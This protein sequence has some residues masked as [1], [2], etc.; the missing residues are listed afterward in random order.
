MPR[1]RVGLMRQVIFVASLLTLFPVRAEVVPLVE[2]ESGTTFGDGRLSAVFDAVD[3]WPS[4]FDIEGKSVI[5]RDS[6]FGAPFAICREK[7][8]LE[9]TLPQPEFLGVRRLS[10][11]AVRADF[12]CE[13]WRLGVIV[14]LFPDQRMVRRHFAFA[15][16][17]DSLTGKI[18]RIWASVGKVRCLEKGDFFVP[19][20][21]PPTRHKPPYREGARLTSGGGQGGGPAAVIGEGDS[22]FGILACLDEM[23]PHADRGNTVVTERN[24]GFALSVDYQTCGW[25]RR[26]EEQTVGD[27]WLVFTPGG[28]ESS[29]ESMPTWFAK[30]GQLP[31]ADR[32]DW[33][34]D[35]VLYSTHPKGNGDELMRDRGGFRAATGYLPYL[36]A[37]G[38]NVIWLRPVEDQWCYIPR[39]YYAL[40]EGVGSENDFAEYVR[41]A[42]GLGIRV[43]RDAVIHGGRS[44]ASNPRAVAHPE[45][46]GVREDGKKEPYWCFD[47]NWPG[48]IDWFGEFVRHETAKY[49]LDG[50]RLDASSGSRHPNWN[51]EIPYER[52]SYS[53]LHGAKAQVENIRRNARSEKPDA[54]TITESHLSAFCAISDAIYD[55]SVLAKRLFDTAMDEG[56]DAMVRN[57]RRWLHEQKL[58]FVPGALNMRYVDNHD[59]IRGEQLFGRS[60]ATALM[61]AL[62]WSGGGFPQ[63]QN[64]SE[65]GAF[66]SFRRIFLIR[67]ALPELRRGSADYMSVKAPSGVFACLRELERL[68]SVVLVNFNPMRMCGNAEVPGFSP[69]AVDLPPYGY[70]VVR[71][72]GRSVA[73]EIGEVAPFVPARDEAKVPR[74]SDGRA[75]A[76][77]LDVFGRKFPVVAELRDFTNGEVSVDYKL[78]HEKTPKGWRIRLDE[79]SSQIGFENLKLV[80]RLPLAE[81][82]YARC[83][84]GLFESPFLVRHPDYDALPGAALC[85]QA[86]RDGAMRWN[87]AHHPFGLV[88]EHAAV[89]ATFGSGAIELHEFGGD[90]VRILDRIGG[91]A[92]MAVCVLGHTKESFAVG[93]S[94]LG[95]D[96]ALARE[97]GTGDARLRYIAGGWEFEEGS[98][99]VRV[100]TNGALAGVWVREG[101]EW[102]RIVGEGGFFTNVGTGRAS[103]TGEWQKSCLQKNGFEVPARMSRKADGRIALEFVNGE[104]RGDG[105]HASRMARP[106][107]VDTKYVFGGAEGFKLE[108]CMATDGILEAGILDWELSLPSVSDSRVC[109]ESAEFSLKDGNYVE[110]K[111]DD[112]RGVSP[113]RMPVYGDLFRIV[114]LGKGTGPFAPS[115]NVRSGFSASIRIGNKHE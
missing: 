72:K 112:W 2:G 45:W 115:P 23:S 53:Q 88:R 64:E 27:Q 32:A 58:S 60:A 92:G 34:R 10:D 50:W 80:V 7:A 49:D 43:M 87:S 77:D 1:F 71:L 12:R 6:C 93:V 100:R 78:V 109:A 11:N 91:D 108:T 38:V 42:H 69:I 107:R 99:R 16:D 75:V 47:F 33:L 96:E 63:I 24:D 4:R 86:P 22:G 55:E 113:A 19:G 105:R 15:W 46:V 56:P 20:R 102:K 9:K 110:F 26:G 31:V 5:V 84:E 37:L 28:A 70:T 59:T 52:A 73:D 89:G 68:A 82:W 36:N 14:C 48:W 44:D 97:P 21:Y 62:S 67:A 30:V 85:G 90:G 79:L 29:L 39:D 35:A 41:V 94:A 66:E 40:A 103:N 51:P 98:L 61:A 57:L 8:D 74:V 65:D 76:F 106:V 83:A 114:W 18:T 81:R 17:G 54:A 25:M 13:G 111:F 104:L 3:G 101:V 95:V